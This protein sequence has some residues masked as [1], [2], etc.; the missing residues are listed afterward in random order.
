M[1]GGLALFGHSVLAENLDEEYKNFWGRI[2]LEKITPAELTKILEDGDNKVFTDKT[3]IFDKKYNIF[4]I[5]Y[6]TSLEMTVRLFKDQTSL[7]AEIMPDTGNCKVSLQKV[8]KFNNSDA[9]YRWGVFALEHPVS[10]QLQLVKTTPS[11]GIPIS[12]YLYMLESHLQIAF[13]Y[14]FP[15]IR[16]TFCEE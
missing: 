12:D 4:A 14:V 15:N 6:E 16:K 13:A 5:H 8:N 11:Y 2:S 7:R 3:E 1:I 9:A 10:K